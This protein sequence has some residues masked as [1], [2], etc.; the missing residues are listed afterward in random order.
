MEY[1]EGINI[2]RP[3]ANMAAGGVKRTL[4]MRML[5]G[6]QLFGAAWRMGVNLILPQ[7]TQPAP[8]C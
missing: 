3:L 6:I 8:A 5:K 2:I 7:T 1:I 4:I